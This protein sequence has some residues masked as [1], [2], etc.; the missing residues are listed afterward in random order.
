MPEITRHNYREILKINTLQIQYCLHTMLIK[1]FHCTHYK[2]SCNHMDVTSSDQV[3]KIRTAKL[4]P[5][6]NHFS[7]PPEF[8]L[9]SLVPEM[10][11]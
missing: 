2:S 9:K 1:N 11:S 6:Q 8:V 10:Q 7:S 4:L 5:I 3:V